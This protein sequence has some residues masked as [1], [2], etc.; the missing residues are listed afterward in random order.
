MSI[1]DVLLDTPDITVLG[2]PNQID[3]LLDQGAQGDRG[4]RFFTGT[5]NP[6]SPGVLPG[7]EDFILGDVF[8]NSSTGAEFSWF[9]LYVQTPSGNIWEPVLRLQPGIY[10][11]HIDATFN[12]SGIATITVPTIEISPESTITDV[13]RYVVQITPVFYSRP[14]SLV[15]NTKEINSGNLQT[16][17]EA[18]EY[19]SGSWQP[20][21]GIVELGVTISV[22]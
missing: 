21:E 20:L 9:Y 10:N 22:V 18:V 19:N 13:N 15:I 14:I 5:G 17:I 6:N 12:S 4:S 3:L 11:R 1:F 2:P 16:I 8:L 7:G